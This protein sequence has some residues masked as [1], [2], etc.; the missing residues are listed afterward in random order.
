MKKTLTINLSGSVFHIDD[1]A[2]DKLYSYLTQINRHFGGDEDAKEIVADIE[3]RIAEIFTEKLKD[4]GEVINLSHVE[5][6]IVIMGTP[7]AMSNEE[8]P[9]QEKTTRK[10]TFRVR[11]KRLYRDPD[12]KVLGGVCSG[13]GAYFAVD[14][15]LIRILFVLAFFVPVGS[16]VLVY[17]IMWIVV[18]K[19][20]T[21]A[22]RLEMKGEEVNI[23]NIS[24]SIKEEIQ[25]VKENF[26]NYRTSPAYTRSR[27]GLHEATTVIG[28]I[29]GAFLKVFLVLLGVLFL[30]IGVIALIALFGTLFLSHGILSM[31]PFDNGLEHLNLFFTQSSALTWIWVG[32]GLVIGIPLVLLAYAG[33]KMIFHIQT[34]NH[35]MGS[36][37]GGLFLVGIIILLVTGGKTLGEFS[38]TATVT[39]HEMLASPSDTIY[40]TAKADPGE[41]ELLSSIDPDIR[42][43][44]LKIGTMNG[45]DILIGEPELKIEKGGDSSTELVVNRISR[46]YTVTKARQNAEEIQYKYQ[47]KDSL[48]NLQPAYMLPENWRNQHIKL[49][50]DVPVGKTVYLDESLKSLLWD[51]PNTSDIY[52]YDMVGKYWTMKTDGLTLVNRA[53]PK[54]K[55]ETQIKQIKK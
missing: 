41:K 39:N 31:T 55:Q 43:N 32:I 4:G 34:S 3:A 28:S 21:T 44:R 16:S 14:P 8:E 25:D 45:K 46:G 20:T 47:L 38:K 37:F 35:V 22:Q 52:D 24:K 49:R 30:V 11:G 2:Y 33:I 17:L 26:R 1:D 6:V 18:P 7:E 54:A 19:A 42:F 36:V 53:A 23:D 50:I 9:E 48:I 10:T 51:V 27:N 29:L 13:L 15:V 5:E 12:D 40:I